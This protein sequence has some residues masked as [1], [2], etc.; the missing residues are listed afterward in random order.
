MAVVILAGTG[1]TTKAATY[2]R[3]LETWVRAA[4]RQLPRINLEAE[5]RNG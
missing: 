3:E 2:L 5:A 1:P 4:K